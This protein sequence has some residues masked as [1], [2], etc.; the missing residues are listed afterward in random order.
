MNNK[1][2]GCLTPLGITAALVTLLAIGGAW[3]LQGGLMFSPG[4]LNEVQGS[5]LGEVSSHAE[6][7]GQCSA[8]HTAPWDT[9]TMSTRCLD[10]HENIAATLDNPTSLHGFLQE[11]VRASSGSVPLECRECHTE[12]K[13][14][15]AS[16]TTM[17]MMDF[18]HGRTGYSLTGHPAHADGTPFACRD[19]H[20]GY[21]TPPTDAV[22]ID[23]HNQ[24]NAAYTAEHA[25]VFGLA[26]LGCHDGEDTYG[27]TFDH[28]KL[29]F[30][31][32][33]KHAQSD[34]AGCH[35]GMTT[36]AALRDTPAD[37]FTCHRT[38]DVHAGQLGTDC[39]ECHSP[40]GWLPATFDHSKTAFPL[41][42][43]HVEAECTECHDNH[44]YKGTPADCFSCHADDDEHEGRFGTDCE[45]CHTPEGWEPA[46][47]DHNRS[48][49]K[50]TGAHIE[51]DCAACHVNEVFQGT[52]TVCYEC[53]K[54]DD[55][56][57]GHLGTKCETCHNT[58]VWKP[59]TFDHSTTVFPL[60]G[61]HLNVGCMTCH[62]DQ[63]FMNTPSNCYDCHRGEDTHNGR[64]GIN[65][66]TCHSTTRWKPATF[67]HSISRFPLTG[68]HVDVACESCHV[69]GQ[70]EGTPSDC[71]A[72][73][74]NDDEHGGRFGT[75]CAACHSTS[76][77][78]GATF[79][80]SLASFPLTGAHVNV[81]CESCHANGVFDGT[82]SSCVGC[83]A[84]PSE[85]AGQFGTDCAACHSTNAWK[86][87]G[88]NGPH[89]FPMN[90]GDADTC[91]DCHV[92]SLT[93]WTCYTCHDQGEVIQE[94]DDE[95]LGDISNCLRCHPTGDKEER[96][97]DGGDDDD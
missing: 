12:H 46:K 1:R 59:S 27:D 15:L 23:C 53:H 34:C 31:L 37:C 88:Y 33:G 60:T 35:Q 21:S 82:P 13:G 6:I 44:V 94:H 64:F 97:G 26:C 52:P 78:E 55:V 92:G 9:A 40:E 56:H 96:E 54:T 90:H 2:L 18:P 83:H 57:V 38:D 20:E 51:V 84:E 87:A 11:D 36:L 70:F 32:L 75:N 7:A 30:A 76:T 25:A 8:C 5:P 29:E 41:V 73:H 67:D 17:Q 63:T 89:T 47:F 48:V 91:S 74:Q 28:N 10:C 43:E 61:A 62:A 95:G 45:T 72:C 3:L 16:L 69:N 42:G 19:C 85:H 4:G 39:A 71:F 77:W 24:I 14:P 49:F 22:C 58:T 93:T 68:A 86:P 50:L 80:H 65:C 81:S 66:A 79:D